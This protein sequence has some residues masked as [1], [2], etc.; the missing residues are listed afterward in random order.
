M[1]G[2]RSPR[3]TM[4]WAAAATW[5]SSLLLCLRAGPASGQAGCRVNGTQAD[6]SGLYLLRVPA[7]LDPDTQVLDLSY[8]RIA[9]IGDTDLA[10][11]SGLR[12]L[13]LGYN[14]ISWLAEGAFA[15][16]PRLEELDLFNNSL[17]AV[18]G[19]AL[20]P[21]KRLARLDLSNNL[22]RTVQL[23]PVFGELAG[24]RDLSIGGD[25]VHSLRKDDF[26]SLSFAPLDR[27]ALKTGSSLAEYER[28]SLSRLRARSVWTDIA[29]DHR[30]QLL[31]ALLA[32]L[33]RTPA[34][35]LRFRKLF[36]FTYYTGRDD[37]FAGLRGSAVRNLTFFRGKFNENLLSIILA[38]V[39]G[40]RV[41]DLTLEAID[42]ARSPNASAHLPD[43]AELD[44][45]RLALK[46]ISNPD[47]LRFNQRFRWLRRV[48]SLVVN[49]VNFNYVPCEAWR[50]MRVMRL[51]D[52]SRN[53]LRDDYIYNRRC[54]Y[55]GTMRYLEEIRLGTNLIGSLRTIA[56]LT[57]EWPRLRALDLSHNQIGG[58]QLP[59]PWGQPL[60][61]LELRHNAV[62]AAT[63]ACLPRTLRH[64]DL[65]HSR[66]ER[67]DPGWF[68]LASNLS[69]LLLSGNRIKF[70]PADW[71][72][73]SLRRLE[74]DG[75]SFGVIGPGS[76]RRMPRLSV[77]A[78]GNNP[79]HCTCDL[80]RFVGEARAGEL[81]LLGWPADYI[82]YHPAGLV[83]TRVAEYAPGRL[84]C[85]VGLAL[86][87]SVSVTA[88][89]AVGA[90]VL[91]WRYDLPWYV[92]ATWQ[93]VRSRAR[94]SAQG[95]AGPRPYHA[96]VSYSH[97][98]AT[99]VRE[100]LLRRLEGSQPPYRVCIHERDFTPGRWIIDNII[101]HMEG[102]RKV[103]FV[104]SRSFVDSEWCN[105]ELYF[106]HQRA[107]GR[108][109]HDA[110][111]L[112][113]E[114]ISPASLPGRFCR[115]RRLLASRTYLEWPAEPSRRPFF[116]AQLE[117]LLGRPEAVVSPDSPGSLPL[118]NWLP[119]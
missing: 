65:S 85:D 113:K 63:F 54:R 50:E 107:P 56:R 10:R 68:A 21:L 37:L 96:F 58:C 23:S 29:V 88:S 5:L 12:V 91:C 43:L 112:L 101:D 69:T 49:L 17:R 6:C 77:L 28:G 2:W 97:A 32:D 105:Y 106:A 118:G 72:A 13:L 81:T 39:Q 45:D 19:A 4:P 7:G 110:V 41:R 70:I 117:S 15:A 90:T 82:C 11:L 40:S 51:I 3:S 115:L 30:P 18:P 104:L 44:L 103:L 95:P 26:L 62:S 114:P 76:F 67:L 34:T 22:Y 57:A 98:D 111:L 47:V 27:I 61:R 74:L 1:G 14:N 46:E 80:H 93:V 31:P 48:N 38:N 109:L 9:G 36:E 42:F 94:A 52:I 78:A 71:K 83:D 86:A 25:L 20:A 64:L 73:P 119:G 75:N 55:A 79:Y 35:S 89:L 60:T 8:N 33:Y 53:Q 87:V 84:Q 102:S 100:H 66:L 16:N 116:W 92:R 59:C 24:L 108:S 99:W